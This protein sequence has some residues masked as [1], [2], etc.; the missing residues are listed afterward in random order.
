[1]AKIIRLL[2]V[3]SKHRP[4]PNVLGPKM[5]EKSKAQDL[6]SV[7]LDLYALDHLIDE[8]LNPQKHIFHKFSDHEKDH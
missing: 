8:H 7:Q 4:S 3:L 5:M 6:R 1:M 2:D